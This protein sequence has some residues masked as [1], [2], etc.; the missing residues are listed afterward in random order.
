MTIVFSSW[1]SRLSL[2]IRPFV[3]FVALVGLHCG[4]RPSLPVCLR[5]PHHFVNITFVICPPSSPSSS[6]SFHLLFPD[7]VHRS[8]FFSTICLD[9]LCSI[10]ITNT[11]NMTCW[12][13]VPVA[14]LHRTKPHAQCNCSWK[15]VSHLAAPYL[16]GTGDG[17]TTRTATDHPGSGRYIWSPSTLDHRASPL[18]PGGFRGPHLTSLLSRARRGSHPI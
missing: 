1:L 6:S 12:L 9:I 18:S 8:C 7:V 10:N 13:K 17:P 5:L 2:L 4:A 16:H 3:S 15:V 11:I 14:S